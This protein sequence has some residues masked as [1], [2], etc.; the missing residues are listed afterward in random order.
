MD[1]RLRGGTH[2]VPAIVGCGVALGRAAEAAEDA[3]DKA[4]LRARFEEA[5]LRAIPD[6]VVSGAGE[7]RVWNT[8]N[9]GFP[10][11]TG[12][13]L[14]V[15]LDL[16]GLAASRG[17]ACAS[18]TEKASHVLAAMNLPRDLVNSAIR[19]SFLPLVT[20]DELDRGAAIVADCVGILRRG[21]R[22]PM[23]P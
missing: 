21:E 20:E 1:G 23:Q 4:C 12:E 10:G 16:A 22:N 9:I 8:S 19:F 18:G 3:G 14:L 13:A 17:A 15:R 7:D 2:N 11:V 6:A 5:V